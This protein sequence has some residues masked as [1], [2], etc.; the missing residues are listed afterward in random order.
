MERSL[1]NVDGGQKGR[2]AGFMLKCVKAKR[3]VFVGE[4]QFSRGIEGEI[5]AHNSIDLITH[6]LD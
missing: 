5:I 3:S 2:M 4:I 6:G 1:G